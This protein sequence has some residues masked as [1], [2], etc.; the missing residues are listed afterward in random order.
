MNKSMSKEPSK[1]PPKPKEE[2]EE[3]IE[4]ELIRNNQKK[5]RDDVR[6]MKETM[7]YDKKEEF[8]DFHEKVTNILDEQEEIFATH[9]TAIKED[10]KL[11]NQ[12]SELISTVQGVGFV[13]YD[14]DA[15]VDKLEGIIRRKLKI[16][17]LLSKKV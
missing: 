9:M 8:F 13:D 3:D 5:A 4:V 15:Y 6:V 12:E 7:K 11:L 1:E 2:V 17:N 16:Y 10:A 14:I